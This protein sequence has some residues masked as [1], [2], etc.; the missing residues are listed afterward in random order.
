M[1]RFLIVAAVCVIAAPAFAGSDLLPVKGVG[2][3]T[4][5]MATG[6][7]APLVDQTRVL[8]PSIWAAT[9]SSGYFWGGQKIAPPKEIYL[10]NG[11]IAEGAAF[12]GFGFSYATNSDP[13]AET[14]IMFYHSENLRNTQPKIPNFLAAFAFSGLAGTVTPADRT[15]YWGWT[16]AV[17]LV[18]PVVISGADLD[19][20][21]LTDFGY[22]Q[23]FSLDSVTTNPPNAI[24]GPRICGDPNVDLTATGIEDVFELY[25]DPNYIP[26]PGYVDPNLTHYVGAYWFGGVVFAQFYMELFAPGCPNRGDSSRYCQADI[27]DFNCIVGLP[28][29][30]QLL[31]N[32]GC[33]SGC[34]LLDGDVDP[35]DPFFPGDGAVGLPDLAEMLGQYGDDCNLP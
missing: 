18:T 2:Y 22:T 29:L 28:D 31:G 33:T 19:N 24:I 7:Q 30:A 15:L 27:A 23:W 13:G 1:K 6:E 20:D 32:Y 12:G 34:T 9:S 3:R 25:N 16:Y 14:I 5:D 8:G 35:Y 11:D 17:E 26:A 21:L 4:Y 10:E